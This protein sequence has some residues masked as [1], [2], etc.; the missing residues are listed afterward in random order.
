MS[1]RYAFY[2]LLSAELFVDAVYEG[3]SDTNMKAEP[4]RKVFPK[5]G[6]SGGFRK[7]N[8]SWYQ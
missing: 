8:P 1:I 2:E 7:V 5:L 6:T 3:G 4:L